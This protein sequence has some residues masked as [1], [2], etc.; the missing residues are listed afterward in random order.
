[1]RNQD[2]YERL[3]LVSP[4]APNTRP[5]IKPRAAAIRSRGLVLGTARADGVAVTAE[6][7]LSC[8]GTASALK[9]IGR[10]KA[11]PTCAETSAVA[12]GAGKR[13]GEADPT[14]AAILSGASAVCTTSA[15][16]VS[17]S[18]GTCTAGCFAADS[19]C[20]P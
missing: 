13:T 6:L 18:E 1:M 12:V 19:L 16:F 5:R 17:G 4:I 11:M 15:G 7:G 8:S 14:E 3:D 2:F 9:V 20:A 10:G